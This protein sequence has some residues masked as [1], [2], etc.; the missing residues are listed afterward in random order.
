MANVFE[1]HY[2]ILTGV[3][4]GNG[5][6]SMVLSRGYIGEDLTFTDNQ[7]LT[8]WVDSALTIIED[9]YTTTRRWKRMILLGSETAAVLELKLKDQAMHDHRGL[10]EIFQTALAKTWPKNDKAVDHLPSKGKNKRVLEGADE[11]SAKKKSKSSMNHVT[12]R[13][14]P[15]SGQNLRQLRRSARHAPKPSVTT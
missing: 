7:P 1:H 6:D 3:F 5:K 4:G 9:W 8:A 10:D 14:P 15:L 13:N 2:N 12:P 11:E